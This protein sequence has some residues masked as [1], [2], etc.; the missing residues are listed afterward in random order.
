M[1]IRDSHNTELRNAQA[2]LEAQETGILN[3]C[4][5]YDPQC[6]YMRVSEEEYAR[7]NFLRL[8]DL[9]GAE[10][11]YYSMNGAVSEPTEY[12]LS[13]YAGLDDSIISVDGTRYASLRM[14]IVSAGGY[15]CR[16]EMDHMDIE[17]G[18]KQYIFDDGRLFDGKTWT[19]LSAQWRTFENKAYLDIHVLEEY[20]S[21][22]FDFKEKCVSVSFAP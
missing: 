22:L 10:I 8:Y 7:E 1:C 17:L 6:C 3:Y 19:D 11:R 16:E 20:F 12:Y 2:V 14:A 18:G 5:D 15:A 21:L 9:E 13:D 4:T